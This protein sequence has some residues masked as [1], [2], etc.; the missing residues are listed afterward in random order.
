MLAACE[1]SNEARL[2]WTMN[3][4]K[5]KEI[6]FF[7]VNFIKLDNM[8]SEMGEKYSTYFHFIAIND[9]N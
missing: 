4:Q 2:N 1:Q 8:E 6:I 5:K 3:F 7:C 9:F